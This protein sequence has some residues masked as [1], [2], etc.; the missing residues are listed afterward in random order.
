MAAPVAHDVTVAEHPSSRCHRAASSGCTSSVHRSRPFASTGRL[1]IQLLFERRCLRPMT[2]ARSLATVPRSSVLT[3]ARLAPSACRRAAA[4]ARS[5]TIS[6]G[7]SSTVPDGVRS[8]SG[9]RSV[10][11]PRS[12]PLG[13][14]RTASRPSP[15]GRPA[16]QI[17]VRSGA[18][19]QIDEPFGAAPRGER[20]QDRR[21]G[22][23][24]R[25]T[26]S[27][28]ETFVVV[29]VDVDYRTHVARGSR[30]AATW[31]PSRSACRGGAVN[32]AGEYLA[33]FRWANCEK[34]TS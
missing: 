9:I 27:I 13:A 6:V 32:D 25:R 11:S 17:A 16:E 8:I 15:P 34:N 20:R 2:T 4:R 12:M 5:A 7:A 3:V 18:K 28:G 14:A 24:R 10:N 1:C 33:T 29:R 23:A 21:R 22:V 26:E 31:S 30:S 19:R